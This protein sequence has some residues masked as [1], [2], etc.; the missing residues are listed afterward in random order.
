MLIVLLSGNS[1]MAKMFGCMK[2]LCEILQHDVLIFQ[3]DI[4]NAL[5]LR[6]LLSIWKK[7]SSQYEHTSSLSLKWFRYA[8]TGIEADLRQTGFCLLSI[9]SILIYPTFIDVVSSSTE[10]GS[11]SF[12]LLY[13]L[14]QLCRDMS[15]KNLNLGSK[16]GGLTSF[17]LWEKIITAMRKQE[18]RLLRIPI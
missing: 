13:L 12:L 9:I 2:P 4:L 16:L 14:R 11:K 1:F 7:Y 15:I 3:L 8:R 17:H 18:S 5:N 10:V 6:S